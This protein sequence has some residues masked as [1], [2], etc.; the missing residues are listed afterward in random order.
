MTVHD[1]GL[2]FEMAAV[3]SGHH[4]LLG[5]RVRAESHS[6]TLTIESAPGRG[7]LVRA[8]LPVSGLALADRDE[9]EC[10]DT[11]TEVR[12]DLGAHPAPVKS[13]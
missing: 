5:M 13:H 10:I 8:E 9:P 2:G 1:N 4:G 3:P 7:T 12:A 11:H 6:G